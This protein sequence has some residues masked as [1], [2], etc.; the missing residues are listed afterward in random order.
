MRARSKELLDR[1]IDAM[2][3]A[4]GVYNLPN[5]PYRVESFA[6]LAIN[7]WELLLKAK[8]LADNGNRLKSLYVRKSGTKKRSRYDRTRSGTP[9]THSIEWLARSMVEQK[10]LDEAVQ[11]NI[12]A[13]VELRDGAVHFY[14]H[15][16]VLVEQ[17]QEV[18]I[19]CIKNFV[20]VVRDW[21]GRDLSGFYIY[22]I[23]LSFDEPKA[24]LE[25]VRLS[26]EEKNLLQ[27]LDGLKSGYEDEAARYSVAVNVEL[28]FVRSKS[29]QATAVRLSKN[30][31]AR[32]IRLTDEQ[33]RERYPWDYQELTRRCRERY[34]DFKVNGKYHKIRKSL[35]GDQRYVYVRYLDSSNPNSS[36]K[37]F[38]SQA[39]LGELDR[40]YK[41]KLIGAG[42][43]RC[44]I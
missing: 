26:K 23:P 36:K 3:A 42:A 12:E 1:A 13:L 19:A 27:Y 24:P 20:T 21:F 31:D 18:G 25:S 5:L 29:S 16:S 35:E 39:I 8:W 17:I 37:A 41:K 4:I 40:W 2:V 44:I 10:I 38:Y 22:P 33:M 15:A 7:A 43:Y 11:R 34:K 6:I 9:K 32:P 30:P 14:H 28:R